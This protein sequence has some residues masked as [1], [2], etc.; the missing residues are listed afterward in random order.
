MFG[1]RTHIEL[2]DLSLEGQ[3]K[4][5]LDEMLDH[6]HDS[7]WYLGF[8]AGMLVA[9]FGIFVGS[10]VLRLVGEGEAGSVISWGA[11]AIFIGVIP[12]SFWQMRKAQ[13]KLGQFLEH[14]EEL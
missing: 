3:F 8:N 12:V 9:G 14:K 10:I 5:K 13:K 4:K 11:T 7:G 2:E 1:K 6:E